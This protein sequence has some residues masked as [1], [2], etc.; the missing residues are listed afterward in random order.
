M[1][2]AEDYREARILAAEIAET[3]SKPKFYKDLRRERELSFHMLH[4]DPI[5]ERSRLIV[6]ERDEHFGHGL[7][8]SEKVATDAGIIVQNESSRIGNYPSGTKRAILLVQLAGLLHDI[9]RRMPN[10]AHQGALAAAKILS[11]LPL[12]DF[13]RGWIVNSIENHE[14]FVEPTPLESAEGQLLSDALYDADKFRWGPD[15]F[16]ET[17]WDMILP[18]AVPIRLLLSHF[19]KGMDGVKRIAGTFRTE[20]GKKYGPEFIDIG[21]AIGYKLYEELMKRFPPEKAEAR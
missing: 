12:E 13:E 21:L 5:L 18:D 10:H 16:T 7:R 6:R 15:N 19:P 17:L 2:A 1:A 20:T 3:F 4:S 14:A 11:D 8:H 9:K